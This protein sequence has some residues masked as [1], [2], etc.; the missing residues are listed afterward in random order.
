[1]VSRRGVDANFAGMKNTSDIINL[2]ESEMLAECKRV[3]K[4][5]PGMSSAIALR[6]D[7]IDIDAWVL[8]Q[9]R[10]WYLQQ[11][12]EAPVELLPIEDV[13]RDVNLTATP[14]GV[15]T[16]TVPPCC[17]RPVE[18]QLDGW[19]C[20]VTSFAQPGEPIAQHQLS[21]WIRAGV[22]RPVIVDHGDHLQLY[23]I[24]AGTTPSLTTAR[25]VIVPPNN[26]YIF[27][28]SLLPS[29]I[30]PLLPAYL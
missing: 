9:T 25:C 19:K 2:S 20:P 6:Q 21:P 1:M 15:V 26:R 30:P 29:L 17:V 12:L 27:H 10:V 13:A 23:S 11:L 24:P 8:T 16:A 5:E 22:N 4:L 7:G 14:D 28:R 3:M 18:W